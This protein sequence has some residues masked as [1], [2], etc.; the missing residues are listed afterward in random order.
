MKVVHL[1]VL[2]PLLNHP[3]CYTFEFL[4]PGPIHMAAREAYY[5]ILLTIHLFRFIPQLL[6]KVQALRYF[7][8]LAIYYLL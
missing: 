5:H 8:L 2:S 7:H 4:L 1:F 6:Q 3:I